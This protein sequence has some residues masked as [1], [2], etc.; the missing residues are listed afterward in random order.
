MSDTVLILGE[1]GSG[2]STA[3]RTL[4][5]EETFLINSLGKDLPFKGSRN[6]YTTFNKETNPKGNMV[7]TTH[8]QVIMQWLNHINEK[9]PHIHY[10]VI[11]DNTHQSSMEYL[12]RIRETTWDKW[13][14]IA[15]NMITLV[16]HAKTLRPDLTVF[17]LHHVTTE[18]DGLLEAKKIKAQT[19]GKLVDQKLSS[20]ESYFT[21]VLLAEKVYNPKTEEVEHFFLTRDGDSTTKSPLGMFD[22][23]NI[24]NDLAL[25]ANTIN[26]YYN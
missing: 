26:K 8:A 18:G 11:D 17:F 10:V 19:L 24:P 16:Q 15:A 2:K 1:S 5:P 22:E 13:N 4:P 9:L 3:I 23:K 14:D 12:R 25:V 20:Y 6:M 21:V 7:V